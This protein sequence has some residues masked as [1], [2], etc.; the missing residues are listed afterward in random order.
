MVD[1]AMNAGALGAKINGSGGGG[2]MFAIAGPEAAGGVSE[3]LQ[4]ESERVWRVKV[5]AG[6]TIDE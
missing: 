2:C 4:R 5:D 6:V 1:T 3:A